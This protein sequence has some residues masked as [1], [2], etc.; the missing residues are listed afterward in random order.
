MSLGMVSQASSAVAA[1]ILSA[2]SWPYLFAVNVPFGVVVEP[3]PGAGPT[4]R[5]ANWTG[6]DSA[7]LGGLAG[8]PVGTPASPFTSR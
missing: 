1:A 5:L 8:R 4:E 3:R 7:R 6:R 2:A